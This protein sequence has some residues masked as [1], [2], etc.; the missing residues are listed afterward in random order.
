[1]PYELFIG[2]FAADEIESLRVFDQRRILTAIEKHL[3]SQP[4]FPCGSYGL[5]S[6]VSSMT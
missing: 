2:E 4:T 6:S 5:A 3:S 1:M